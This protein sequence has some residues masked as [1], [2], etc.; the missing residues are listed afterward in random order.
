MRKANRKLNVFRETGPKKAPFL[1]N[2]CN[3]NRT[4]D[5]KMGSVYPAS[6][7]NQKNLYAIQIVRGTCIVHL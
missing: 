2:P 7:N 6:V 1:L 4:Y 5:R 3:G